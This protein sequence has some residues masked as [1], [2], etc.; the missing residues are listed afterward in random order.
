MDSHP[1]LR[2]RSTH[3]QAPSALFAQP[4]S[5]IVRRA[6]RHWRLIIAAGSLLLAA[7]CGGDDTG[8]PTGAGGST[9]SGGTAG[10]GGKADAGADVAMGGSMATGGGGGAGGGDAA[11]PDGSG[12][13]TI[14]PPPVEAGRDATGEIVSC[15]D[16]GDPTIDSDFDG[17]PDCNDLCPLNNPKTAP[18][19]CGCA[20]GDDDVDGDGTPDCNDQCPND[21]NKTMPGT[22]GCGV[23]DMQDT[24]GDGRVDCLDACPRDPAQRDPG[25]CGCVNIVNDPLCLA[26]RYSFNGA[27]TVATDTGHGPAANGTVVNTVLG[28]EAGPGGVTLAGGISDQYVNLPPNL[29]SRAGNNAT[30]ETWVMWNPTNRTA[31]DPWERIF[32]FGSSDNGPQQGNGVTYFFLTPW[33]GGSTLP[34]AVLTNGGIGG[35][36]LIEGGDAPMGVMTHYAVVVDG[37]LKN[38]K[39]YIDGV[40]VPPNSPGATLR[41]ATTLSNLD[42]SHMW[43]GRSQFAADREFAGTIFEFR[44]YTKALSADQIVA[45]GLAGPDTLAGVVDGGSG[46][47]A[48]ERA[49]DA[50]ADV[51]AQ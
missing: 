17:T 5:A 1:T 13:T 8:V 39:L 41:P 27:G 6:R 40:V 30:I 31:P 10:S 9:G 18:G 44:I 15:P 20:V 11:R 29:I 28:T 45:N 19:I 50:A 7:A 36:N 35:E 49:G 12:G 33:A 42:D 24:D 46:D 47:A 22:C 21:R 37:T 34:R 38:M 14:T 48:A 4:F 32:D 51:T 2:S 26:H 25:P 23:S 43:L 3:R 16:G